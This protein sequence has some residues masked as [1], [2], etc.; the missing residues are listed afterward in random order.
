MLLIDVKCWTRPCPP[1]SKVFEYF[2]QSVISTTAYRAFSMFLNLF[3]CERRGDEVEE[4][5]EEEEPTIL[6]LVR[7][8]YWKHLHPEAYIMKRWKI[9]VQYG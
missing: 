7:L 6:S 8:L 1:S 2:T 4:K 3:E 5:E 9:L